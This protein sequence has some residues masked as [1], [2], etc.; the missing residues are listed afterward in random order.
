MEKV[1]RRERKQKGMSYCK[2][3]CTEKEREKRQRER[4]KYSEKGHKIERKINEEKTL[5]IVFFAYS[6]EWNECTARTW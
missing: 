6:F 2:R 3:A 1:R 5:P 4:M